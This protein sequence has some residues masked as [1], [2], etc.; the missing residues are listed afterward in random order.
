MADLTPTVIP[1]SDETDPETITR[2]INPNKNEFT[3]LPY[4]H[5]YF[6]ANLHRGVEY[7]PTGTTSDYTHFRD[8]ITHQKTCFRVE[9]QT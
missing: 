9:E 8:G 4:G 7:G 6:V 3:D 2:T 1:D 5:D